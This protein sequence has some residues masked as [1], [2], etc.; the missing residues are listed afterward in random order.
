MLHKIEFLYIIKYNME[1]S[2][3]WESFTNTKKHDLFKKY[4][5]YMIEDNEDKHKND[6]IDE[7]TYI[8]NKFILQTLKKD[9]TNSK[10]IEKSDIIM[11]DNIIYQI[12]NIEKNNDGLI[13]ISNDKTRQSKIKDYNYKYRKRNNNINEN[14]AFLIQ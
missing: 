13:Y 3:E 8:K 7:I 2:N 1:G 11:K 6:I 9:K 12:K 10:N 4:V 14:S 5:E